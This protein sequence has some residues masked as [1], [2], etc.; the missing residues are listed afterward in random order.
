MQADIPAAKKLLAQWPTP[1]F[2]AGSELG[3][4][5]PFPA[6]SLDKEFAWTPTHPLVDAYKAARPMPY[7][8]PS[9]P[10]IAAL[11][12]VRPQENYCKLSEAGTIQAGDDGRMKFVPSA[13]GKHRYLIFDPASK[14]KVIRAFIELAST[15]QVPRAPRFR[16]QQKKQ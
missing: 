8:A 2:A 11:Q 3:E 7:D 12:A 13:D 6:S 10:M 4:A 15:K 9:A 5:L 16:P 14:D 1:I